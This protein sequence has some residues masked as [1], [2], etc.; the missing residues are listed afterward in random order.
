MK[1]SKAT[2]GQVKR[3]NRQL[4]LRA[5]YS[6]LAENRAALAQETGLTKPAVSSLIAELID[7]GL[8]VEEGFGEST[9]SGGKR[10]RLLRFVPESRQVIGVSINDS[11][12]LAVL[13]NLNGQIIAEHT[14]EI[15]PEEDFFTVLVEV[16]NGL[17]AQLSAPL[18]CIGVG[19][20]AVVDD[21]DGIV[22][23]APQVGWKNFPLTQK[24]TAYYDVPAYVSNSTELAAMAQLAFGNTASP[25]SLVT[26]LVGEGVGVGV[27]SSD[28]NYHRGS[29]IGYL[30]LHDKSVKEYL[31]WSHVKQRAREL[32]LIQH[33]K[34]LY[35]HLRHAILQGDSAALL[36]EDE[37]T[38]HV[39]QIFSWTIALLRPKH[40]SLA[41]GI[42]DLGQ[43][44]LD[45]VI[46]KTA[47]RVIPELVEA[48]AFSLDKTHNLISM[49]AAA[50][51]VRYELGLV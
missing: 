17:V 30:M 40:I 9:D 18:L 25:S 26:V 22:R 47:T 28:V 34:F 15:V 33:K 3:H 36:L 21:E 24:L 7:D 29:D 42:A 35:L 8:L 23:Y 43:R 27:V 5:V 46:E 20:Q 31:G 19:I 10:P 39:A 16:I 48:T 32:G 12:I 44:F 6:G 49:G 50:R 41:G 51:A 45:V 14:S 38:S 2:K 13:T 1:S 37:L 11:Y 4:L